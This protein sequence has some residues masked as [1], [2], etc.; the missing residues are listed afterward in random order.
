[1]RTL[2]LKH[3]LVNG[4]T[5]TVVTIILLERDE[6]MRLAEEKVLVT[7]TNGLDPIVMYLSDDVEG[8]S[9]LFANEMQLASERAGTPFEF[10]NVSADP[11]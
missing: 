5:P 2:T 4:A 1:M 6:V 11:S 9:T 7:E 3:E 8:D 10:F